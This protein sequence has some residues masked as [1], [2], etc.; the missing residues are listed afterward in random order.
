VPTKKKMSRLRGVG[1]G[2]GLFAFYAAASLVPV[3]VLGMVLLHGY[4][5]QAVEQGIAQGR[6]QA[7]VIEEMAV[8]PALRGI[9]LSRGLSTVE[10]D[11]LQSATDLAIFSGSVAR[12][13]LRTFAG[14]VVFSDDGIDRSSVGTSEPAFRAAINGSTAAV[15][16]KDPRPSSALQCGRSLPIL[17]S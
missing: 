11:R 8:A 16:L 14:P 1:T 5:R 17:H 4:R 10:R 9:D 12:L 13:R 6:A 7:E 3:T 15:V 2:S